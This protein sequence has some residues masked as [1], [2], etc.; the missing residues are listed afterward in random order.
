M[1]Y[2]SETSKEVKKFLAKHPEIISRYVE[3]VEKI[4]KN[5]HRPEWV[6]AKPYIW[7]EWHYRMRIGKYRFLY[8]VIDDIILVYFYDADSR[9]DIYK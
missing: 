1:S 8:E 7:H 4:E 2:K 5:P 9:G 3:K 6:D